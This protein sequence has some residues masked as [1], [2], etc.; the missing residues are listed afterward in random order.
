MLADDHA[1]VRHGLRLVL[2]AEPALEVVAE[3]GNGVEAVWLGLAQDTEPRELA[4]VGQAHG[5]ASGSRTIA[6]VLI[7]TRSWL[8]S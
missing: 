3:A 4:A 2:D 7:R 5:P 1:V 6:S 8:K